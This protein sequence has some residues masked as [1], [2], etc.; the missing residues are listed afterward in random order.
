MTNAASEPA[1]SFPRNSHAFPGDL[2]GR[3]T[4]GRWLYEFA[5]DGSFFFGQEGIPYSIS[6]DDQSLEIDGMTLTRID[7]SGSGIE[8][9]WRSSDQTQERRFRSDGTDIYYATYGDSWPGIYEDH[10]STITRLEKRA[11]V[12]VDGP[13]L[14]FQPVGAIWQ[15]AA[16]ASTGDELTLYFSTGVLVWT[17]A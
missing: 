3:W 1:A 10:G 14:T 6:G 17:S 7:Q 13:L 12:I 2:V 11:F 9:L 5:D 8:G 15:P 16:Y 4:D